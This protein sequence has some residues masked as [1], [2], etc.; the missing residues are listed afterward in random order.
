MNQHY[1]APGSHTALC[2]LTQREMHNST[3]KQGQMQQKGKWKVTDRRSKHK[4]LPA[5][6]EKLHNELT[7]IMRE[8]SE[9]TQQQYPEPNVCLGTTVVSLTS[10]IL[11]TS[12][13][14]STYSSV[15]SFEASI[16][17]ASLIPRP[18]VPR[19][20]GKLEREKRKEGLVN[21]H[22]TSCNS[23]G[24]LAELIKT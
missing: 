4:L 5:E 19:P 24:M 20:V 3:W 22:T 10:Q 1:T 13:K 17:S 14:A 16:I 6:E 18:S 15:V 21:G 23:A 8:Q 7:K 2:H 9:E 12:Q 11:Y